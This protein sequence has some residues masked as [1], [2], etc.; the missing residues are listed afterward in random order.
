MYKIAHRQSGK[1]AQSRFANIPGPTLQ[2]STF[3]RTCTT[4]TTIP[5]AG[6]LIPILVDEILPGDTI[7]L[8]PTLF[9]RFATLLKPIMENIYLEYWAFAVPNRLLWAN[10]ERFCGAQDNPD[11]TTDYTVPIMVADDEEGH[12]EGSLS[13]YFGIPTQIPSIEHQSLW[14]RAYAKIWNEWFRDQNLQDSAHLD[15]GNGPDDPADYPIQPRAKFHDYFTSCLPW[16]QKGQP[17]SIA[18]GASAP[19]SGTLD[20]TGKEGADIKFS[21]GDL[22]DTP[23]YYQA[24]D[25][26]VYVGYTGDPGYPTNVWHWSDPGLEVD[27]SQGTVDLSTATAITINSLRLAIQFQRLLERDAR[28]GT[29]YTEMLQS[30]FGV[31]SPDFRLQRS[32]LLTYGTAMIN[33]VA[34]PSTNRS[35][36]SQLTMGQ[37]G[38][39]G[40]IITPCKPVVKSFTEHSVLLML[41]AIRADLK[42]QQGLN[43]MFS[44]QSRFEYF[45]PA[46][47]HLGEQ[48]VL[49]Q[50]IYAQGPDVLNEDEQ[51]VD[52]DAF[53]YQERWA[54]YRYKPSIVTG[55]MRSNAATPLDTY[56][57]A[58]DFDDLP[59]LSPEFIVEDPPITRII[60][61]NET[62]FLLD[63]YFSYKHTRPMPT[64]SV[65]GMMDHF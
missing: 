36:P 63:C 16:P 50:E 32:E 38:A 44:R 8:Q 22:Q 48:A 29:R 34:V 55:G 62:Q 46:L 39:F 4:T 1:S 18:L 33:F 37:L 40:Q 13:D 51:P 60:A 21:G 31:T 24:N 25:R 27:L 54:E 41:V 52:L 2:R 47:A 65:P 30:H 43:R 64:Y 42:Y 23:L 10:W 49:N 20:V 5:Q 15:T 11:D 7:N 58:Q 9:G 6:K 17:V 45:Y 59:V 57:L 53:G 12:L 19:L 56:H 14:H 28:A 61:F 26:T 35:T 3:D